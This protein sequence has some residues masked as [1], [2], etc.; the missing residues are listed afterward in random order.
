MYT[1]INRT[2][3]LIEALNRYCL[4]P[5]RAPKPLPTRTT[6][7][8]VKKRLSSGSGGV[9]K[10]KKIGTDTYYVGSFASYCH[11]LCYWWAYASIEV[12]LY[13]LFLRGSSLEAVGLQLRPYTRNTR[14]RQTADSEKI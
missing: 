6:S 8:F 5:F 11:L 7:K 13:C 12:L 2:T 4:N 10:K 3:L 9:K 14:L 1:S